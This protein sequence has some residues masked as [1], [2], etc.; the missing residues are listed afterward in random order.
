VGVRPDRRPERV[1]R[2]GTFISRVRE[3]PTKREE[4]PK[5]RARGR[6]RNLRDKPAEASSTTARKGNNHP[7]T[8]QLMEAVVER[9]SITAQSKAACLKRRLEPPD[10]EPY[11][12]WCGRT[13]R[14]LLGT[15]PTRFQLSLYYQRNRRPVLSECMRQ[16]RPAP[17]PADASATLSLQP[18]PTWVLTGV[19]AEV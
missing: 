10:T 15:P 12:R 6:G 8:T 7:S 1:V 11:V 2:I 3:M 17:L 13:G 14:P 19:L 9:S 16:D 5:F 4:K 18:L